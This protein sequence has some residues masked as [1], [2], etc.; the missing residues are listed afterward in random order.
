[1]FIPPKKHIDQFADQ[2][3]PMGKVRLQNSYLVLDKAVAEL[4]FSHV[5]NVYVSY[6]A[7]VKKVFV[8]SS[9]DEIFRKLHSPALLML[10]DKS[11]QGD[12]SIALHETLIDY[13]LDSTDRSLSYEIR[14][15][16]KM[17]VVQL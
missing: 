17:L 5:T 2:P 1:M 7:E 6:R 10:K 16:K 15:E 12:K 14:E 13:E 8:V 11:S 3:S 9:E 4:I